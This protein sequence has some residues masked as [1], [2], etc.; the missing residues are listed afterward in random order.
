[1]K[2]KEL[3]NAHWLHFLRH[4]LLIWLCLS[5][6]FHFQWPCQTNRNFQPV[7][8]HWKAP[9]CTFTPHN[10]SRKYN[11]RSLMYPYFNLL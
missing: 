9:I 11:L 10:S 5:H 4:N 1:M 7:C 3:D 2:V 6:F 8:T